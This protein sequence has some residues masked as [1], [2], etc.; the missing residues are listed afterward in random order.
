[1]VPPM[2]TSET[3]TVM[4]SALN[5][6]KFRSVVKKVVKYRFTSIIALRNFEFDPHKKT[7]KQKPVPPVTRQIS[8]TQNIHELVA[9]PQCSP[10]PS[11]RPLAGLTQQSAAERDG[12]RYTR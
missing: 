3:V 8:W 10:G 2:P 7:I 4:V 6:G 9:G 11:P 12:G 5:G 1:M